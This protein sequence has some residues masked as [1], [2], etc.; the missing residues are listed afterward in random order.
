MW[1]EER[2]TDDGHRLI[3][4]GYPEI[5]TAVSIP[6]GSM[7]SYATYKQ[8]PVSTVVFPL[9]SQGL[10]QWCLKEILDYYETVDAE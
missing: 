1:A 8:Q 7:A 10:N 5:L 3:S 9:L 2:W 6:V 4:L